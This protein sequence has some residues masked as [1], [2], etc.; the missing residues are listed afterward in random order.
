MGIEHNMRTLA[1]HIFCFSVFLF[2]CFSAAAS[3]QTSTTAEQQQ[4]VFAY[5]L[6]QN[7][8]NKTA[9]E[10]FDKYL[11]N[12]PKGERRGDALYF[13][14][15]IHWQNGKRD[16]ASKMLADV[17]E[18][19]V[20]P[21]HKLNFLRGRLAVEQSKFE[22]AL[23]VLEPVA[24]DKLEADERAPLLYLRGLAYKGTKNL[25]GAQDA[26]AA[27]A[28]IESSV[29]DR[30]LLE[31]ARV[32]ALLDKTADA[33]KT[34]DKCLAL[35][36]T[37]VAAEA[38][39]LAGDLAYSGNKFEDAIKYYNTVLTQHQT[40]PHFAP[41][42]MQML[43][44]ML[45]A[46]QYGPLLTTFEQYKAK[47][48]LQDRAAAWFLAGRGNQQL[49]KHKEAVSLFETVVAVKTNSPI[50]D[51]IL[52]RLA[53]SQNALGDLDAMGTTL[54][55]LAKDHP[56]SQYNASGDYLLAQ[57]DIQR[58]RPT[59]AA[60][61]LSS[62]IN[63]GREHPY[64][65]QALVERARLYTAGSQF[66]P[67]VKD[68]E[69]YLK[70]AEEPNQSLAGVNETLVRLCDV[71][72]RLGKFKESGE[73]AAKLLEKENLPPL[74]EQEALFRQALVQIQLEKYKESA[75]SFEKLSTKHPQNA[76]IGQVAY[77]RGLLLLSEG[78]ADDSIKQLQAAIGDPHLPDDLKA[79]ALLLISL[80]QR[81]RNEHDN[82]A[83]TLGQLEKVIT[84]ERMREI[85][86]LWMGRYYV[87]KDPRTAFRY[88]YPLVDGKRKV[89][90][91]QKTEALF[92][93]GQGLRG[94][95][96]LDLAI[97]SFKEVE[98]MGHGYG[99]LARMEVARTQAEAGKLSDAL[100]TYRG[101]MIAQ[102]AGVASTAMLESAQIQ[103]Q[104][105]A[106]LKRASDDEGA[107]K[108]IKEA[109]NLLYRLTV[110]YSAA[111]LSP[112]PELAHLERAEIA[113]DAGKPD[114]AA[115]SLKELRERF[116]DTPY[117][118]YA[119]AVQLIEQKKDA[120]AATLLRKLRQQ[121]LDARLAARVHARLKELEA[122]P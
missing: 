5:R 83:V 102:D 97:Q 66:E 35:G 56:Q 13:R 54:N 61:R 64:Y 78:K 32:Q 39:R 92:L 15:L 122:A 120:D 93:V 90:E 45:Y 46:Q 117:A 17:P 88:V 2:F 116:A 121:T 62:I 70:L 111:E 101:L 43:W 82:A 100:E 108:A 23:K 4:F 40:S 79:N 106:N 95:K 1:R 8:D 49:G 103:R 91:V 80:R 84:L 99:L 96:K 27:A 67:A 26:L 57:A 11:D 3:A 118:N 41:S 81:E 94:V 65:P 107:G 112:V 73:V 110:L 30:S 53:E 22:E 52:Y 10:A 20:V 36:N 31:L 48:D 51:Q 77:Y 105:A 87:H 59:E 98:A 114:D 19:K 29:K 9:A 104:L 42:V 69:A 119:Q 68:Y 28:Q 115:V 60:A 109:Y 71:Q 12:F 38:A 72:F 85:D 86:L 16:E 58:N 37:S 24:L 34:L 89:D 76:F 75:A 74:I 7:G 14:A 21:P 55:R 6:L 25:T 63:R 50:E 18:L 113:A 47:L 44:S 33:I